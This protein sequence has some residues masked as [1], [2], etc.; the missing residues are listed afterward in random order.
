MN[1]IIKEVPI[2][3]VNKFVGV[4]AAVHDCHGATWRSAIDADTPNLG[5]AVIGWQLLPVALPVGQ[6]IHVMC[7]FIVSDLWR[8]RARAIVG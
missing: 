2:P 6:V 4:D 7:I 3:E 5:F 8:A 1:E